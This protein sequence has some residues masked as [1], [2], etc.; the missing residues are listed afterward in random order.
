MHSKGRSS[1]AEGRPMWEAWQW[2]WGA[3]VRACVRAEM[4]SGE[5]RQTKKGGTK[6]PVVP[7]PG[8]ERGSPN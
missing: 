6:W 4:E 8:R 5:G 1:D 3:G 7:G 2:P